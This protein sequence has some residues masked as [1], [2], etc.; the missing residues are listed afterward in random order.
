M[1]V[2]R[3]GGGGGGSLIAD[4]GLQLQQAD[5]EEDLELAAEAALL[6]A[7]MAGQLSV[8]HQL[9]PHDR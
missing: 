8:R 3:R 7:E 5:E 1:M 2:K 6:E 9:P 4:G